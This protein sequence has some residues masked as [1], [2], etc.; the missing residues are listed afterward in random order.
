MHWI[1]RQISQNFPVWI[2]SR[3]HAFIQKCTVLAST[4]PSS[5]ENAISPPAATCSLCRA[6]YTCTHTCTYMYMYMYVPS[7]GRWW[8]RAPSLSGCSPARTPSAATWRTASSCR[9]ARHRCSGARWRS[10]RSPGD[11]CRAGS[12]ATSSR[13]SSCIYMYMY[14][15]SRR[16]L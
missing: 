10:P 16:K 6:A 13:W 11:R 3:T 12:W 8:C 9:T 15:Y 2:D 7:A 5:D 14:M 1:I 4:F